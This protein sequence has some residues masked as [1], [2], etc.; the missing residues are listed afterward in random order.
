MPKPR[1][2]HRTDLLTGTARRGGDHRG[3]GMDDTGRFTGAS[4]WGRVY[5]SRFCPDCLAASGGAWKLRW[6]LVWTFACLQHRCL[7]VD[8]CPR[9]GG[10]QRYRY[11][12]R[13]AA[14]RPGQC[15]NPAV[16]TPRGDSRCVT[17]TSGKHR[18][19]AS[20]QSTQC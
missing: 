16:G 13:H 17:L 18:C 6:R 9:C 12:V 19:F 1:Q 5:G 8:R 14:A 3:F 4:P 2:G 20:Q 7:L 15:A 10:G 11:R